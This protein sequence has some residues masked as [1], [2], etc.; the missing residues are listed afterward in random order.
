M[1]ERY[2]VLEGDTIESIANMFG[3]LPTQIIELN[4]L[5][6]LNGLIPGTEIL[7]PPAIG[8]ERFTTYRVQRGDNLYAISQRYNIDL[9]TLAE[10]NG[11]DIYNYLYPNQLLLVPKEG[12]K[13]YITGEEDTLND[14][15]SKL[16]TTVNKI[17][18]D[19][20]GIYLL[21]DQIVTYKEK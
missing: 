20:E 13:V 15:A 8:E 1:Y 7:I 14:V 12:V 18:L 19:N 10:I 5:E 21:P 3:V 6:G 16:N 2:V 11:L 17:L 4:G 9:E